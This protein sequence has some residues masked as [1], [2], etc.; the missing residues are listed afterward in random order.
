MTPAPLRVVAI[1]AHLADKSYHNSATEAYD[2]ALWG[3]DVNKHLLLALDHEPVPDEH[4][5]LL[6]DFFRRCRRAPG[7]SCSTCRLDAQAG[8][9]A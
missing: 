8:E 5:P 1:D 9:G 6:T 3:A 2:F 4:L 7:S